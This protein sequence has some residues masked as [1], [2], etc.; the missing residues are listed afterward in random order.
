MFT[1]LYGLLVPQASAVLVSGS[2][3]TLENSDLATVNSAVS[4]YAT[5]SLEV[6]KLL[7]FIVIIWWVKYIISKVFWLFGGSWQ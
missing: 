4:S 5:T 7:W 6:F 3:V 1:Y 2:W